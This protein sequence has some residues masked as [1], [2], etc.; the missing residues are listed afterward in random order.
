MIRV[1]FCETVNK[2]CL[3]IDENGGDSTLIGKVRDKNLFISTLAEA[4]PVE[5]ESA[6]AEINVF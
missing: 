2:R 1:F 5:S 4:V 3:F 6:V